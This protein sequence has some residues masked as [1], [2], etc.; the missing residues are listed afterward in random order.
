MIPLNSGKDRHPKG[1]L[2]LQILQEL[3]FCETAV[4]EPP[5]LGT[6]AEDGNLQ[7]DAATG[8]C[9]YRVSL[10]CGRWVEFTAELEGPGIK[11]SSQVPVSRMENHP[12]NFK[13]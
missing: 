1:D 4:A 12:S 2:T 9:R 11:E 7:L 8:G 13:S 10:D 5:M 3:P 6:L